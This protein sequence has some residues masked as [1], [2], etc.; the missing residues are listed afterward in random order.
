M[1]YI[2][3]YLIQYVIF[4]NISIILKYSLHIKYNLHIFVLRGFDPTQ[5]FWGGEGG[6]DLDKSQNQFSN[7]FIYT[8]NYIDSQRT[9][10]APVRNV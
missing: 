6:G 8:E 10:M 4:I 1:L 9:T 2:I 7:M 5:T 3:K